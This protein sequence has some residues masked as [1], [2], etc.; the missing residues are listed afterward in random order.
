MKK[1]FMMLTMVFASVVAANAQSKTA[2]SNVF[3]YDMGELYYNSAN[4]DQQN[5][6]ET[7]WFAKYGRI[8]KTYMKL[9]QYTTTLSGFTMSYKGKD[10]GVMIVNLAKIDDAKNIKQYLGVYNGQAKFFID[11]DATALKNSKS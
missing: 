9:S 2:E 8:A 10:A 11:I 3:I 5:K 7:G 4:Y 6:V 1:L